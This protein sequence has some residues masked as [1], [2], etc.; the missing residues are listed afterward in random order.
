MSDT[1]DRDSLLHIHN[2]ILPKLAEKV[3]QNL[4]E[5]IPMFDDFRLE[6]VVD[7]WTKDRQNPSQKELS[8][9]N[10]NVARM[11]LRLQLIGFQRP[12]ISAFDVAK[13]L[14]FHLEHTTYS[15]GPD[16]HTKW[17]E[18]RYFQ[19][20]TNPELDQIAQQFAGE[21]I[22]DITNQLSTAG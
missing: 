1:K 15:V 11:G 14:I 9:E 4:A 17:Q 8:L 19:P 10:G 6:K 3:Y 5:V 2:Q 21:V 18:K 20:W 7:T 22:D 16:L 13:D 12:G